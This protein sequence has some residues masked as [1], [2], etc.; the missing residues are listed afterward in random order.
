MQAKEGQSLLT[1]DGVAKASS[2]QVLKGGKEVNMQR[3][4]RERLLNEGTA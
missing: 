2:E 1:R 3:W 4:G